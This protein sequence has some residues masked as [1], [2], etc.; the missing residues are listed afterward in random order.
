MTS[1]LSLTQALVA[2]PSVTPDDAGCQALIGA[3]LRDAGFEVTHLRFG[4]TDNLWA[5]HGSGAPV[6]ALVGHTDVVPPGPLERWSSAPFEPVVRDGRLYGRG[7]A[8]MKSAIAA[9]TL[10]AERFVAAHPGHPGTLAILYTSDEEGPAR[11]GIQAVM[12]WLAERGIRLDYALIGE[13]S[14]GAIQGDRI[15]IGRRGSMHGYLTIKGIQGHVAYPEQARNPIHQFAPALTEL[16]ATRFDGG[17]AHFPPTSFQIY[18]VKA[19]TGANN[20]IPG[21]LQVNFNFRF[22]TASTEASLRACV[23]DVLAR[24]GIEYELR[25]RVASIPFLTE[26]TTLI[27]AVVASCREHLGVD[28]VLDTGGGTS[29]GRFIAPTGAEV[30]ELGPLNDSIHKVDEWVRI[31]DLEPLAHSYGGVIERLLG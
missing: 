22:G 23:E 19:G 9:L 30:V 24:H 7:A 8:D 25:T 15:R 29:D 12:P 16:V 4:E 28:P 21:D 2:L 27:G 11:D 26:P 31:A 1:V 10:A 6:L 18:E 3:R 20:V 5:T 13:P 14:S 17:N